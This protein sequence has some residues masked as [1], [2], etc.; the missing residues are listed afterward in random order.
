MFVAQV[1]FQFKNRE[2]FL[3]IVE[4]GSNG[5]AGTVTCELSP[6]VLL[7]DARFPAQKRDERLIDVSVPD[8]LASVRKEK[9]CWLTGFYVDLSELLLWPDLFPLVD[10]LADEGVNWLG[11]GRRG[12]V[13]RNIQ[14]A[15]GVVGQDLS[16]L[17]DQHLFR[18]PA[19][20]SY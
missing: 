14:T 10:A 19:H 5:G 1:L 20:A 8:A 18:L 12:F 9:L 15:G 16:S 6:T 7:R 3:G 17:W 11:L 4:H 13:H 2:G